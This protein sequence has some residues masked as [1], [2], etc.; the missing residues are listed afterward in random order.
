[1]AMMSF[2]ALL[3]LGDGLAGHVLDRVLVEFLEEGRVG[4]ALHREHQQRLEKG[5]G[6]AGIELFDRLGR[7]G[8]LLRI[9]HGLQLGLQTVVGVPQGGVAV[10]RDE[11]IVLSV[12]SLDALQALDHGLIEKGCRFYEGLVHV[13]LVVSWP[14]VVR[15]GLRAD[16]LVELR[17]A[18][19]SGAGHVP[20]C[21][22]TFSPPA[23]GGVVSP[24][25]S[26]L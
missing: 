26:E 2:A 10:D 19:D 6:P 23:T 22:A 21:F 9:H 18:F 14:G 20:E 12:E 16:A 5:V 13:P 17:V 3:G 1:M 4:L 8:L 11:G 7:R 15:E 24:S 25:A